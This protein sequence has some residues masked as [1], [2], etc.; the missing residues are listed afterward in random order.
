MSII[1]TLQEFDGKEIGEDD[2][3]EPIIGKLIPGLTRTELKELEGRL[4]CR[5]PP[6]IND[7]LL[8]TRGLE[9]A[10]EF[11]D[12]SGLLLQGQFDNKEL[13][14][15]G[16]PVAADGL[17]NFWVVDLEPNSKDFGPVFYVCFNPKV[18]VWQA[19]TFEE[20]IAQL[21]AFASFEEGS[22]INLVYDNYAQHIWN[23]NPN[24]IPPEKAM[25]PGDPDLGLFVQSLKKGY[26]FIDL[27]RARVGEGFSWGRW[28]AKTEIKRYN[29]LRLF[30]YRKAPN[31]LGKLFGQ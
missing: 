18:V 30:A 22:A 14:P 3:G 12:F 8:M 27:R 24:L 21:I 1:S 23:E 13:F 16:L 15:Y 29:S 9:P 17:G 2:H 6:H 5:L 19:K 26:M 4:P 28:G 25:H 10:L 20:F 31:F 7:L 11:M